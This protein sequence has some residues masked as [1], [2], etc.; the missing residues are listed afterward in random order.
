[1]KPQ[2]K[3]SNA[4]T[5]K[6]FANKEI[7][8]SDLCTYLNNPIP[9]AKPQF[10]DLAEN[11]NDATSWIETFSTRRKELED[12][13]EAA[14]RAGNDPEELKEL[15]RQERALEIESAKASRT[16]A[17]TIADKAS[18]AIDKHRMA[19]D[20]RTTA[21]VRTPRTD[22]AADTPAAPETGSAAGTGSSTT[23]EEITR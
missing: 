16:S 13:Y 4:I 1:M 11:S 17:R 10:A 9:D 14:E 12:R 6:D 3:L 23:G 2:M 19:R 5:T 21:Y 18:A 20:S 15:V 22:A 8:G 7:L